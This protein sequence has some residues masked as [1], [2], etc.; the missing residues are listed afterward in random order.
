[1]TAGFGPPFFFEGFPDRPLSFQDPQAIR[2]YPV[3]IPSAPVLEHEISAQLRAGDFAAAVAAAAACRR[4]WP[5]AAAGWYL[6]SIAALA[7]GQADAALALVNGWLR[8]HPA[9]S[10]W[11]L[12]K[13][14]CLLALGRREPAV[15]AAL[16]AASTA[17]ELPAT[18][19]A[20]GVFLVVQAADYAKALEIYDRA[21][22]CSPADR[23]LRHKR[24]WVE[25]LLGHFERATTDF[26]AILAAS[27][28]DADALKWLADL[29]RQTRDSNRIAAMQ[30]ALSAAAP[31]STQAA[32]LHFALAKSYEDLGEHDKSWSHLVT[33]NRLE[34]AR[35]KYDPMLDR[36]IMERIIAGFGQIETEAA[37]RTGESPI[38]IVGLPRSGTTLVERIIGGHSLAHAAGELQAL[39]EAVRFASQ[40]ELGKP[41]RGLELAAMLPR[42]DAGL[43]AREYLARTRTMRGERPRFIDKQPI[44]F[45]YCPLILRAFPK[46]RIVHLTRHP[47]AVCYAIYK[48]RVQEGGLR[49]AYDLSEIGEFYLGYRRMMAHWHEV[50]PGRILDVA[51]EDVVCALEPT[52]R[53]ILDYLGLP[54]EARCL[55]F[56]RN[57]A[58]STTSSVVQVR[59]GLYDTSVSQWRHYAKHL[60]SLAAQLA[61]G[62]VPIE[63]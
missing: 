19:D 3:S 28:G 21:V 22:R 13:A 26:E 56:D 47:M 60:T 37:D 41:R 38:F 10:Q 48:V 57:P 58:P 5:D 52:T 44:N 46:A 12:R 17:Q 55:E 49:F 31:D 23:A 29:R 14:E 43:I 50:L 42:L 8:E 9:D 11:L 2:F 54:F 35:F 4:A 18:L 62:G 7:S 33:G 61:A 59:Q 24:A 53:R 25:L 51:Y 16:A 30:A 15:E 20:I 40:P 34:R 6:G 45:Y 32:T 1:L 36:A 63:Q 39:P 27:P